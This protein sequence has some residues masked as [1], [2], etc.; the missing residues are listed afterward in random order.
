MDS[1]V[2]DAYGRQAV[3]FQPFSLLFVTRFRVV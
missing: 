1:P 3:G 2:S